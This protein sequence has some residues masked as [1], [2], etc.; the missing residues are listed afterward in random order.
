ML[1]LKA[2]SMPSLLSVPAVV[3]WLHPARQSRTQYYTPTPQVQRVA[4]ATVLVSVV[5]CRSPVPIKFFLMISSLEVCAQARSVSHLR[6]CHV[7]APHQAAS[8]RPWCSACGRRQAT[9]QVACSRRP[10]GCVASLPLSLLSRFRLWRAHATRE[11]G[12]LR[13]H[14][15]PP[16]CLARCQ[17]ALAAYRSH[18]ATDCRLG[19]AGAGLLSS[20][21]GGVARHSAGTEGAGRGGSAAGGAGAQDAAREKA[22]AARRQAYEAARRQLQPLVEA[23][24]EVRTR[25]SVHVDRTGGP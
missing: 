20:I 23:K 13:A 19:D 17:S 18:A 6:A 16:I 9:H 15:R 2:P 21:L 8:S 22:A 5:Q 24:A 10:Q 3:C 7:Q 12:R 1:R 14:A 4:A 25:T 11:A